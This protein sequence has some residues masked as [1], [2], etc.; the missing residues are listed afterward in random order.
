MVLPTSVVRKLENKT[1]NEFINQTI[2]QEFA[3]IPANMIEK[4]IDELYLS[5][6]NPMFFMFIALTIVFV[7]KDFINVSQM[8]V[9]RNDLSALI[10]INKLTKDKKVVNKKKKR[11]KKE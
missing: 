8:N 7:I 10:K 11:G 2:N 6:I 9:L 1:V 5:H 3:I 4:H